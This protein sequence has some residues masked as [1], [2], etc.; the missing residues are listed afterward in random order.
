MDKQTII[1][2][3]KNNNIKLEV[4]YDYCIENGKDEIKTSA[5]ITALIRLPTIMWMDWYNVA[6]EY[7]RRKFNICILR[8][9]NGKIIHVY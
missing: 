5:L 6:L 3:T 1:D 2:I 7:Y 9:K 8:D 4:I